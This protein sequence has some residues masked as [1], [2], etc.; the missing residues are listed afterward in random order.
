MEASKRIKKKR[1]KGAIAKIEN[2]NKYKK[3]ANRNIKKDKSQQ[4]NKK[5]D[6]RS[7]LQEQKRKE[8]KINRI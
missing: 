8:N 7:N 5:K 2:V 3:K 1:M 6:K 4:I